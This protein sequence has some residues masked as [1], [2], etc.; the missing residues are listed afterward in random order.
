M[1]V[2][3]YKRV[4]ELIIFLEETRKT[5]ELAKVVKR[6]KVLEDNMVA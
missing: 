5:A 3:D 1:M 4:N 2:G 6:D